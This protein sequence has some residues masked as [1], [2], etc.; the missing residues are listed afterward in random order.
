VDAREEILDAVAAAMT[1]I[2]WREAI[3][4]GAPVAIKPNLGWDLFMPGAV[5]SPRVVE[6]VIRVIRDWAGP[7]YLVEADQV[8]VDCERAL[9]QTRM[10]RL[11][12]EYGVTWVNL[13]REPFTRV[14]VPEPLA[15]A[16]LD[17]PEILTRTHLVTVPVLKTHN[18]TRLTGA[19]KNQWGCLPT[20]R[21]NYHPV[22]SEALCDLAR[23]LRPALAVMDGTVGMEGDAPKSGRP[24]I[25]NL[26]LASRDPVALDT[27]A[28]EIMALDDAPI[29]HLELCERAGIGIHERSR[30]RVVGRGGAPVAAVPRLPFA[31]ARHNPVSWIEQALR[32]SL[33]R[34]LVFETPLLRLPCLGARLWYLGW[35]HLGPGRGLR[36]AVMKAYPHADQWR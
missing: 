10:D 32:A 35:Y 27:I 34:R 5:T 31:R 30:I 33:V 22:V 13:S 6:G 23:V 7:L 11:C 2:D 4:R 36:D 24:R 15:V 9:R 21:H 18:K 1:A 26:V 8:L 16:Q 28:A 19:I 25:C 12:R 29:R 20:F 3:P 14:P 17:L